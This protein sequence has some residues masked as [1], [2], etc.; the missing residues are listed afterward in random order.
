LSSEEYIKNQIKKIK[1]ELENS[2]KNHS[3]LNDLGVGYHLLG[4][5]EKAMY[6]LKSAVDINPENATYMYN[7]AN[8]YAELEDY[9]LAKKFYIDALQINPEHI[10]SLTN[11]ADCYEASGELENAKELFEY[12]TKLAP[13]N[14]LAFFNFGNFQLRQNQHIQAVK[15]YEKAIV[16]E[17]SFVD[18]YYNIAWI[19]TEVQAYDEALT[20]A[21]KGFDVDPNHTDLLEIL[22]KI[23]NN[24]GQ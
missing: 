13:E 24:L 9:A 23:R 17:E 16:L 19:L 15:N 12:I 18:A 10:P 11:L 8:V 22:S 14:A 21:E 2:P 7:L 3:L 6:P 4:E 5:Y 1:D 20:Y